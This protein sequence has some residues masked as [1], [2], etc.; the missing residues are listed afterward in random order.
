MNADAISTLQE[1]TQQALAEA[2]ALNANTYDLVS[3]PAARRAA[4]TGGIGMGANVARSSFGRES[5]AAGVVG[6]SLPPPPP[7][8]PPAAARAQSLNRYADSPSSGLAP[9]LPL[10]ARGPPGSGTILDTVPPTPADWREDNDSTP[11]EP[12]RSRPMAPLHIDTGSII[13]KHNASSEELMTVTGATPSHARRDSSTGALFRSPAV[14]NRSAK[15]IRERRSESRTGK[16]R[17]LDDTVMDE[18]SP[19]APWDE[20]D[21]AVKPANLILS[22]RNASARRATPRHSPRSGRDMRS[23]DETVLNLSPPPSTIDPPTLSARSLHAVSH[24]PYSSPPAMGVSAGGNR[25]FS[26]TQ[27]LDLPHGP[28]GRPVSHL[29]HMPVTDECIQVALTPSTKV[30]ERPISDLIG[31]DSPT[32]FAARAN[33]RHKRFAEKEAAAS[34]DSERL[35]LFVQFVLAESRIRREQ[36]ASAFEEQDIHVEDLM[37]GLSDSPYQQASLKDSQQNLSCEGTS[38]R[39]SIASSELGESTSQDESDSASRKHESPSSATTNSSGHRPNS[40]WTKDY[41]PCLSPIA[42]MSIV[43]GQDESESRGRA[44]SRWWEGSVSGDAG[45]S[46]GFK[47]LARSKRESKYMGVP[48]EA[49]QSAVFYEP[50]ASASTSAR[51]GSDRQ[52]AGQFVYGDHEYPPE[53]VGWQE[54]GTPV[55]M[56]PPPPLPPTPASAPFT[57]NV[58]QLDVSRLVTLPPPYPR[59][60]P[61]VN[62]SHP[63]L[64]EIRAIVRSLQEKPEIDTIRESYKSQIQAKRRRATSL[65]EHQRSL[66]QQDIEFRASHGELSSSIFEEAEL[67][68]EEKIFDSEKDLAKV[69]FD[70][71]QDV[72]VSPLHAIFTDRV[73]LSTEYMDQLSSRVFSDAQS[74]SPNLPQE[75][76]DERPELLERLTMLKWLFDARETSH[77]QLFDLLTERN[78]KYKALV[79]LPY[80]QQKLD[81][82]VQEARAFFAQ[83]AADRRKTFD[84]EVCDRAQAFLQVIEKTVSRGVEMQLDAFWSIAPQLRELLQKVPNAERSGPFEI[85]IPPEEFQENPSYRKHPLQYLYSLLSHAE[86]SSYQFIESQTNLLCLL[87]EIRNAAI[88][89]RLRS[90]RSDEEAQ[91]LQQSSAAGRATGPQQ[92]QQQQQRWDEWQRAEQARAERQMTEDL[93]EKV[94]LI[95]GQWREALGEELMAVRERVRGWLLEEDG[96]DED[97]A[98]EV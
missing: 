91:E 23:L 90:E 43:T 42:S 26:S 3:P 55:R 77:R 9:N 10:R 1:N 95:E 54:E 49:R 35:D 32:S 58:R 62:N 13:R 89:S 7:G 18:Q 20:D 79:L 12:S 17:A 82:K 19:Q 86:K 33:D 69:D 81:A 34:N 39:T 92:Q 59:H 22:D 48:M 28:E 5:P 80:T 74:P 63:D 96:W 87:H 51:Q 76:G 71:F 98:T 68:L 88:V 65:Q 2:A 66:H 85:Q 93:K 52:G 57:P 36:Y 40:G 8:P 61:A 45:P 41:V 60:H 30:T 14:R 75:E 11:P 46:D 37:Q 72:A 64:A 50:Q 16:G 21:A 70:L 83:D 31:L 29:L 38:K 53:K 78:D 97:Q 44:P 47:V 73:K 27:R 25:R 67:V 24:T 4:S 15:G 84:R 94:G 56:P 6:L